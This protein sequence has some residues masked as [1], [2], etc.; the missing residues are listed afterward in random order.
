MGR[1]G[2]VDGVDER[3]HPLRRNQIPNQKAAVAENS[4]A[5][6]VGGQ[7]SDLDFGGP[8]AAENMSSTTGGHCATLRS[9][10]MSKR[11]V[12]QAH[13]ALLDQCIAD[14]A[15]RRGQRC[16]WPRATC[17]SEAS[18]SASDSGPAGSSASVR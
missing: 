10:Q 4:G 9:V 11:S 13:E 3:P 1:D 18:A 7:I 5:Q 17:P 14:L 15:I 8:T 6:R 2:T 12:A 16:R